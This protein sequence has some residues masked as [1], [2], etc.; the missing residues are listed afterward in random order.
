LILVYTHGFLR[1]G[2][3]GVEAEFD[4]GS[5]NKSA[6]NPRDDVDIDGI[7]ARPVGVA[8]TSLADDG[9]SGLVIRRF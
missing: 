1:S 4:L 6:V 2:K 8:V 5:R 3:I 7:A 9:V